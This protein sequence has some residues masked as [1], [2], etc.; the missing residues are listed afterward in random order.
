MRVLLKLSGE[1]L[2]GPA[3]K[4]I[5]EKSLVRYAREIVDAVLYYIQESGLQNSL[6]SGLV[7]TGGGAE[8][9]NFIPLIKDVSGYEVRKGYPRYMFSASVGSG[10]Y[11]TSATSA[12]GMVLAAKED[13]LP[14][15]VTK[16]EIPEEPVEEEMVEVEV[17][18]ETPSVPDGALFAPEEFGEAIPIEEKPKPAPKTKKVKVA[19][20]EGTGILSIFWS[21]VEKTALKVYDKANEEE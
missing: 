21:K 4:G 18:D 6:R 5:D 8:L 2:G 19:K 9:A 16:P 14:D 17:T 3:G 1:S 11:S 7:I 15:C 12:I 13:H 10:V 20:K